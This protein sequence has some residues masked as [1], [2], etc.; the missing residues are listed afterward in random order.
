LLGCAN[1]VA[2]GDGPKKNVAIVDAIEILLEHDTAGDPITGL[3]WTRKPPHKI[4][5][6]LEQVD[7][8]VSANTVARLLH[9]MNYSL[10]ANHKKLATDA[11]PF[12]DQRFQY[13][14]SLRHR[15]QCYGLP[16]ISVDTKK[17]ELVGNFKNTGAKWDR[18]PV[19]VNDHDF[20]SDSTGVA[21][22]YGIYDLLANRGSVSSESLTIPP[23]LRLI[24][25]P[26]GG[27]GKVPSATV[28]PANSSFPLTPVAAIVVGAMPG[29]PNSKRN[30][31]TPSISP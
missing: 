23:P 4:A 14:S 13:I 11:S 10:R 5:E 15:F 17:R 16:M 12:R 3:K 8:P 18:S 1:W 2:D 27:N 9:N 20:R 24:P 21:I 22:P 19:P 28:A 26:T 25:S 31:L 30:S 7:I 29:R 6:L